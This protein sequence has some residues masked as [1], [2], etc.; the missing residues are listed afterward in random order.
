M[1]SI[2]QRPVNVY[3]LD[4]GIRT[5]HHEFDN[6]RAILGPNIRTPGKS[7]T[8]CNGHGTHVAALAV[9]ARS[10]VATKARAIAV[11]VLDCE[12]RGSCAD[13][14]TGMEWVARDSLIR[15]RRGERS[16]LVMSVG[17]TS[18]ACS[19]TVEAARKLWKAGVFIAAAAGNRGSDACDLYP[20]QSEH[21]VAVGAVDSEDKLYL[22]NNRGSCVDLFAPGV[23][24]WSAGAID[25]DTEMD[26]KSGTSM[27]TP[28][29]GG[30]AAL[31]L[32]VRWALSADQVKEVLISSSTKNKVL[33]KDG[34]VMT[35]T[36]NRMLY[37]PWSRLFADIKMN[38]DSEGDANKNRTDR[39]G[40]SARSGAGGNSSWSFLSLS[41][42]LTP[43]VFP[44][45]TYST[46]QIKRSLAGLAG[47]KAQSIVVRRAKGVKLRCN[48]SEPKQV[49]L[50]FYVPTHPKWAG[51]YAGRI[52]RAIAS[53]K[54][55]ANS[56]EN[57]TVASVD[58]AVRL[59]V[60]L[61][62]VALEVID[63]LGNRGGDGK[64]G[65]NMGTF[66]KALMITLGVV[67]VAMLAYGAYFF[68]VFRVLRVGRDGEHEVDMA[69]AV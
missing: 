48:A 39:V 4:S 38:S 68:K 41:L 33:E 1:A 63:E 23:D 29:V 67:V 13:I 35:G 3:V 9:G 59:N 16:V 5:T 56:L 17:S 25:S 30:T 24:I 31:I 2:A 66:A 65:V 28:L 40:V 21:T 44:A 69:A 27:A 51:S 22:K 37:A 6:N 50:V 57:V 62:E 26:V 18:G 54:L 58:D 43:G 55:R 64:Q 42:T 10:G 14:L 61:P 19:D 46:T 52:K 45:M 49:G 53:G 47:V 32:G 34:E 8:D 12:G 15:R 11:K 60:T 20:A 7:S 36:K